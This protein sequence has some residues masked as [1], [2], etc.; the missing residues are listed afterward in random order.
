[1]RATVDVLIESASISVQQ[2]TESTGLPLARVEAI[3]AGRW[4]PKPAE[5]DVVAAALGVDVKDIQWGHSTN[6]RNIRYFRFGLRED[7]QDD[8]NS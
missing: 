5:R 7:F 3:V 6:P 4:L 8:G 1:M 2:L